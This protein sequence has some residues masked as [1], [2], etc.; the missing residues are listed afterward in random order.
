MD[1]VEKFLDQV[2]TVGLAV[3]FWMFISTAA[4]LMLNN[5]DC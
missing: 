4:F 3:G 2:D 1:I 5:T